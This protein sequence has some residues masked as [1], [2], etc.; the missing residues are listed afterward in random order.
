VGHVRFLSGARASGDFLVVALNDDRSTR[1]LKGENRPVVAARDRARVLGGIATVDAVLV[2]G[3]RDVVRI[4]KSLQPACHS[5]GTDDAAAAAPELETS[6]VLGIE[7]IVVGG[8]KS[9][10]SSRVVERIRASAPEGD[11]N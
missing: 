8:P 7:T 11:R 9:H 2:F 4:L 6:R 10:A 5:R 3:S 1:A